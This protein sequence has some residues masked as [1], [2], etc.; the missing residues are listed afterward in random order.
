MLCVILNLLPVFALFL[1]VQASPGSQRVPKSLAA[2]AWAASGNTNVPANSVAV[3]IPQEDGIHEFRFAGGQTFDPSTATERLLHPDNQA[4][5]VSLSD[6]AAM[7]AANSYDLGGD[8]ICVF[9]T[10][11]ANANQRGQHEGAPRM[12][13]GPGLF[14]Y[15]SANNDAGWKLSAVQ[16]RV[17]V[18][19]L[20]ST[21]WIKDGQV[22]FSVA[23]QLVDNTVNLVER[24]GSGQW[25]SPVQIAVLP[26]HRQI[27][28]FIK[29][30]DDRTLWTDH[31]ERYTWN[32]GSWPQFETNPS[33]QSAH[34]Y[35]IQRKG[36][37]R[38]LQT[39]R[40]WK[41]SL[42]Q[43]PFKFDDSAFASVQLPGGQKELHF[44][45]DGSGTLYEYDIVKPAELKSM[46]QSPSDS[47]ST[48]RNAPL[49]A[50][51]NNVGGEACVYVFHQLFT[52]HTLG[53][54]LFCPRASP[55]WKYGIDL[56]SPNGNGRSAQISGFATGAQQYGKEDK[57]DRGNGSLR[58][59][60]DGY[61][62]RSHT[63]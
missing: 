31:G 27:S 58:D 42:N 44:T 59:N 28:L 55:S 37:R 23:Y 32:S 26:S 10:A 46:A 21:A 1:S 36:S 33:V 34:L 54:A 9:F 57:W 45:T 16:G 35:Q 14:V 43:Y 29:A 11:N 41:E 63:F 17:M 62:A 30:D 56:R 18:Y 19:N 22:V 38:M 13:F 25:S 50:A 8:S 12:P 40:Y 53:M 20:A 6:R 2:T 5:P 60:R 61:Q 48:D 39:P 52:D 49:A 4:L 47:V 15:E 3:Y 24:V 7:S 51:V